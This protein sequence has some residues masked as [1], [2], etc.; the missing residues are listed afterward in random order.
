MTKTQS[1][2]RKHSRL[3]FFILIVCLGPV[4]PSYDLHGTGVACGE[5]RSA[6][7]VVFKSGDTLRFFEN[8][9]IV[10][11]WVLHYSED[12]TI[13]TRRTRTAKI[14]P[15]N[16]RFLL[17]EE[18]YFASS[19]RFCTRLTLFNAARERIWEKCRL[20]DRRI[21]FN[22][23][24][25]YDSAVILVDTDLDESH[26]EMDLITNDDS[27]NIIKKSE[28]EKIVDYE[29]SSGFNYMVLHTKNPYHGKQWD[30]I[31]FIDLKT[32][33]TWQYLFPICF[34]CKRGNIKLRVD[35]SGQV[36][37]IYKNEHRI[38]SREGQL[39]DISVRD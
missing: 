3:G 8:D 1:I 29:V 39:V 17:Y 7:P 28:W 27:I 11:Q 16:R 26:P 35:D 31:F 37:V 4:L 15:D 2:V 30:Y 19:S 24:R 22:L 21:N 33:Q 5:S 32:L 38:F 9:E 10:C 20:K 25:I 34:S 36:E 18:T 13:G 23:T 12:S 6:N 14:S